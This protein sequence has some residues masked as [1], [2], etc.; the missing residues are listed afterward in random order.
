MKGCVWWYR[1]VRQEEGRFNGYTLEF[2]KKCIELEFVPKNSD[3]ISRCKLHDLV[4]VANDNL[5]Q[6]V[7]MYTELVLEIQHI[8]ELNQVCHFVMGLLTWAKCKLEEN[9]P[10]SL[11]YVI[12]KV[13]GLLDVGRSE[14]SRFKKENKFLHKKA[15]HEGEWN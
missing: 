10:P 3:Y 12:T 4:N 13:E 5:C 2:F 11:S 9:W 14:K 15:R 8:H 6:Y 1:T 7:R